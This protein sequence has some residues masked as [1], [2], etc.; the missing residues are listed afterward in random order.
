MPNENLIYLAD[1]E[2]APYGN[3][4]EQF[5][6]ERVLAI[7]DF[8]FSKNVKAIV[9]ACNTAT[10]AAINH[11]RNNYSI[12]IIGLEP[13]LK[14]AI[15]QTKNNKV[16]VIATESTLSS[17]K[18]QSLKNKLASDVF[19]IEKASP[20][21]VEL[22]EKAEIITHSDLLL[23]E[24]ELQP[25]KQA[26][27]DSLVLGC[28]HYPFLTDSI[29]EVLGDEVTIFDSG[30][31]VAK[32]L[33][34][35]LMKNFNPQNKKGTTEYYSSNPLISQETFDKLLNQTVILKKIKAI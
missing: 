22:V 24:K 28:T 15:K 20:L 11:L 35:R 19:L 6:E 25:F 32:E 17:Q 7:A 26:N 10:A 16:G 18:Y 1:S 2:H 12:P 30:L 27:I 5:I 29:I 3:K 8:L 4:S 23:I 14:T 34:R 33:Q 31:P 13:A 21:F 9:V